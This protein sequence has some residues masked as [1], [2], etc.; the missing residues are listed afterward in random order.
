MTIGTFALVV[1]ASAVVALL[2]GWLL[3]RWRGNQ[4]AQA[5]AARVRAE[6]ELAD[7]QA[8]DRERGRT[9]QEAADE[10]ARNFPPEGP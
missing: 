10:F 4:L 5:T 6:S 1:G 2:V 7:R 3:H 8:L 9:D